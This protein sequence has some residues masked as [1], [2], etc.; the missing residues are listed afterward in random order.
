MI[1]LTLAPLQTPLLIVK[2]LGNEEKTLHLK[3]LGFYEGQ[4]IKVLSNHHGNL[5]VS[6]L[7]TKCA[8]DSQLSTKILVR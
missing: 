6:L 5:I 4:T 2:V 3:N 1:P 7:D 8:I